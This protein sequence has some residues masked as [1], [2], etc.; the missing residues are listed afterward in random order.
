MKEN[1]R[2]IDRPAFSLTSGSCKLTSISLQSNSR[3]TRP[4][5]PFSEAKISAVFRNCIFLSSTK[6]FT[7]KKKNTSKYKGE[8]FEMDVINQQF[9]MTTSC[10]LT[11]ISLQSNSRLT[12]SNCP[13]CEAIISTVLP[14]FPYYIYHQQI[15]KHP[16]KYGYNLRLNQPTFSTDRILQINVNFFAVQQSIDNIT[17]SFSWSAHQSGLSFVLHLSSK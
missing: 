15:K 13:F 11:S 9:Q 3:L 17:M 10:K 8:N 7:K 1:L 5:C 6:I 12:T 14:V 16:T 4:K 2:L